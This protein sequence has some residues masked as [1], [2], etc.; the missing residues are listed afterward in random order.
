[1]LSLTFLQ[2]ETISVVGCCCCLL[3][4]VVSFVS[5]HARTYIVKT[6]IRQ[7][8]DVQAD[9][10]KGRCLAACAS[11]SSPVLDCYKYI[12]HP[13]VCCCVVIVPR[14]GINDRR[15]ACTLVGY[16]QLYYTVC[17]QEVGSFDLHLK[18]KCTAR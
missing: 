6:T 2:L 12:V 3:C 1:M 11:S 7:Q 8:T 14:M 4:S 16:K 18:R 15:H 17:V 5:L 10:Q 9:R 13:Y